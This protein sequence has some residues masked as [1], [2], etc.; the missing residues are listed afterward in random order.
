MIGVAGGEEKCL[1]L[2]EALR[3]DAVDYKRDDFAEVLAQACKGGVDV[4]FDNVGG[5]ILDQAID[6]MAP[7]GRIAVSGQISAYDSAAPAS[8]PSDMMKLVYGRLCIEGFLVGD[9][10]EFFPGAWQVIQ[11][12]VEGG[13]II[14]KLDLRHGFACLPEAFVDLFSGRNTGS[15]LVQV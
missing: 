6:C 12:W 3:V 2:R 15:L 8:G 13:D 9:F 11:G 10:S 4:F 14:A 1:W 7:H 5:A